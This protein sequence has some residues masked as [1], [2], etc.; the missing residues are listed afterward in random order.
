MECSEYE[1]ILI[2]YLLGDLDEPQAAECLEHLAN[3]STCR[4]AIE[5][6]RAVL[7]D[8]TDQPQ[9]TVT[10]AESASLAMALTKVVLHPSS[11]AD[12]RS[13]REIMWLALASL[14]AFM[15]IGAVT[16]LHMTGGIQLSPLVSA[17]GLPW[18]ILGGVTILFVTSFIPI[19]VTAR[20]SPLNE[21]T[22]GG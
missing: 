14:I 1:P 22:C 12:P 2:D 19:V 15:L 16:A 6:Y 20:R 10:P 11:S 4:L 5:S 9:L 18:L 17:I 3:C 8:L 13:V 21:L 7:S